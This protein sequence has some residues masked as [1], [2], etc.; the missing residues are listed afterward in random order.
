MNNGHASGMVI[1]EGKTLI[2][3]HAHPDSY[4][5]EIDSV[6]EEIFKHRHPH[7]QQLHGYSLL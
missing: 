4:S 6:L 2:D 1:V 7:H 3:A 5:D